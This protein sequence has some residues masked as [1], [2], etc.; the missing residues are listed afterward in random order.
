MAFCPVD[1]FPEV[2]EEAHDFDCS[3][4]FAQTRNKVSCRLD[5]IGDLSHPAGNGGTKT[6]RRGAPFD[7]PK[8]QQH[9]R[10]QTAA[11]I[12]S[13]TTSVVS[14]SSG[15]FAKFRKSESPSCMW[16]STVSHPSPLSISVGFGFQRVWSRIKIRSIARLLR[17]SIE[18]CREG[19]GIQKGGHFWGGSA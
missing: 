19:L 14:L 17:W 16:S 2:S 1:E 6:Q 13:S 4:G 12:P 11:P 10:A 8:V 15:R 5:R 3:A 9:F 7:D 18:C